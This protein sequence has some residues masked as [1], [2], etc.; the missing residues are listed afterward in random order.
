MMLL[1]ETRDEAT[2]YHSLALQSAPLTCSL[3]PVVGYQAY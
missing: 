1:S 2:E 3:I